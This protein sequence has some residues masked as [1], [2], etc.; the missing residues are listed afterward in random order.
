[1]I[2]RTRIQN[3][4]AKLSVWCPMIDNEDGRRYCEREVNRALL[5]LKRHGGGPVHIN[6]ETRFSK[7][8][9]VKELPAVRTINR[10]VLDGCGVCDWPRI[11]PSAK[12]IVWIG[13][14]KRF[15]EDAMQALE[16][17]LRSHQAVALVS[18]ES[19]YQGYG[20]VSAGIVTAQW[21][22]GNP[23]Y[24]ALTP[25]LIIH[26]GSI[27]ADYF[28]NVF[29]DNAAP[30]WRVSEDGEI[31]DLLGS[32]ECVFE[33][34]ETSFF[35]HYGNCDVVDNQFYR[36]WTSA[37]E[38]FRRKIPDLPFSNN[39]IAQR[40]CKNIPKGT[41][42]HLGILST[43]RAWSLCGNIEG[44]DCF[45]NS[46]GF[47]I[48]GNMSTLIGSS[49]ASPDKLHIGI[50]GDLSFFYDMNALGNRHIGKNLRIIIVNNGMGAE[51]SLYGSAGVQFGDRMQDY[52]GAGGHF[53]NKSK[54]LVRHFASDLGFAY[55]PVSGKEEFERTIETFLC[56]TLG[57]S[58][59]MECFVR[60]KDDQAACDLLSSLEGGGVNSLASMLPKGVKS[61]IKNLIH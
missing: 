21:M 53:G 14:H 27:T 12:V 26:I 13:S 8:F 56:P 1:M 33:M 25:D 41:V 51:F 46:G 7:N 43:F 44:V 50:V 11:S 23:K 48:D 47:G 39:W 57:K 61:L 15:D 35:R 31:R 34:S 6:M 19:L 4:V 22:R 24:T 30:V 28:A 40:M 32:L 42:L 20:A 49:L 3:D 45:C 16:A 5:E 60:Q 36:D 37:E 2:D 38:A 59:V 29:L 55:Y 52:I 9:T 54:D 10:I 58:A 17:Y 18:K